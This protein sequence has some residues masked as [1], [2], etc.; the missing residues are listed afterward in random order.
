MAWRD[1]N[2]ADVWASF[3]DIVEAAEREGPQRIT[4]HGKLGAVLV[5]AKDWAAIREAAKNGIC[6]EADDDIEFPN[7]GPI[8]LKPM[9]FE[10]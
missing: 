10:Q 2:A 9:D 6:E 7:L 1:W 3:S 5:S 4:R 8:G